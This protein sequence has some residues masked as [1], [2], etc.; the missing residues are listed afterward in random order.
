MTFTCITFGAAP[1]TEPVVSVGKTAWAM[2]TSQL[3]PDWLLGSTVILEPYQT[4]LAR[5]GPPALTHGKT[6]TMDGGELT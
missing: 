2:K 4:T 5:P 1:V 3:C 6:L